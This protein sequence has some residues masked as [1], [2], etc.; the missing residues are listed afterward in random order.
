MAVV[1]L[2]QPLW[3]RYALNPPTC[4]D[5]LTG[6][7]R[8]TIETRGGYG[9]RALSLDWLNTAFTPLKVSIAVAYL[10]WALLMR[11]SGLLVLRLAGV[12]FTINRN[13]VPFFG[14]YQGARGPKTCRHRAW[15]GEFIFIYYFK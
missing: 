12:T 14:D 7:E 15:L 5:E 2:W 11:A 1:S 8:F 3:R 6:I 4:G 13:R 9:Q 10:A